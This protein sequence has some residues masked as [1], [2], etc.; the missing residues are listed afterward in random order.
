M[1]EYRGLTIRIGADT[2][3]FTQGIKAMQGAISDTQKNLNQLKKAL[4]FD[5]TSK[6]A[7][8]LYVGELQSQA[9]AATSKVALLRKGIDELNSSMSRS[10]SGKTIGEL[11]SSTDNVELSARRAR[12]SYN[13][14]TDALANVYT[15][16]SKLS[17]ETFD[18]NEDEI[19]KA[20]AELKA[21]GMSASEAKRQ[22][23]EMSTGK[24]FNVE[25]SSI[26]EIVSELQRLIDKREEASKDDPNTTIGISLEEADETLEAIIRM[27]GTWEEYSAALKDANDVST[28]RKYTVEVEKLE[29]QIKSISKAEADVIANN[30]NAEFEEGMQSI[31]DLDTELERAEQRFRTLDE[32]LR[33]DPTNFDVARQRAQALAEATD[34][35]KQKAQALKDKLASMSD[36]EF[37]KMVSEAKNLTQATSEIRDKFV[38]SYS[39]VQRLESMLDRVHS[40]MSKMEVDGQKNTESFSELEEGAKEIE[41]ELQKVKQT[42]AETRSELT[43]SIGATYF[44]QTSDEATEAQRK[45]AELKSEAKTAVGEISTSLYMALQQISQYSERALNSVVDATVNLDDALTEARKTVDGLDEE[46]FQKLKDSAVELSKTQPID[47]ATIL[48]AEALGGQLGV[49]AESVEEFAKVVTGLDVSTNM[50]W[51]TAASEMARFFNI[52]K[53]EG[54]DPADFYQNYG[55]AIVDL[56]NNFATTESEI[57]AMAMRIASAG[58][59]IGMSRADVLGLSAALTSMGVTAE[60]GGSSISTIM[61][62]IDKSVAMGTGG[63]EKYATELGT[64]VEG[65]LDAIAS[66]DDDALDSMGKRFNMTGNNFKKEILGYVDSLGAWSET[67]AK[68]TERSAEDFASAWKADPA[69]TLAA[70]FMGIDGAVD[71]GDNLALILDDLGITSIRQLDLSRRMASNSELVKRGIEDANAAWQENTALETEVARRNES[72]SGQMDIMKNSLDAIKTELGEGLLPIVKLGVGYFQDFSTILDGWSTEAKTAAIVTLGMVTALTTLATIVGTVGPAMYNAYAGVVKLAGVLS[73]IPSALAAH[74]ITSFGDA[75]AAAQ[76]GVGSLAT[77]LFSLSSVGTLLA[78]TLGVAALAAIVYFSKKAY[79]ARKRSDEFKAAISGLDSATR[80]LKSDFESSAEGVES[81]SESVGDAMSVEELTEELNNLKSAAEDILT[82]MNES[83]AMLDKYY[84]VISKY[85]GKGGEATGELEWAVKGLNDTLGTTFEAQDILNGY[86]ETEMGTIENLCGYIDNLIEKRK[87]QAKVD[88]SQQ[89]YTDAYAEYLKLEQNRVKAE[90]EYQELLEREQRYH[91]GV[92]EEELLSDKW[93]TDALKNAY[94]T[95]VAAE[96]AASAAADYTREV[97][98]LMDSAYESQGKLGEMQ[99]YIQSA[100]AGMDEDWAQ[101]LN[102]VQALGD[103]GIEDL[104]TFTSALV[105]AGVSVQDLQNIMDNPSV[106]FADMVREAG[107][108]AGEAG[109]VLGI[110]ID[111]INDYN[112]KEG[113]ATLELDTD[114]ATEGAE[115]AKEEIESQEIEVPM[116]VKQEGTAN[117]D[118][119]AASTGGIEIP[120]TLASG[121][122]MSQ[123]SETKGA[124]DELTSADQTI[125]VKADD[126]DASPKLVNV[127]GLVNNIPTGKTIYVYANTSSADAALNSLNSRINAMSSSVTV[128]T[129]SAAGGIRYHADGMIVDRPS[130]LGT[131]DIVGEA[132]AEAIIPLTNRRY[133]KPFADTV[134]EGMLSQL[135]DMRNETTYNITVNAVGD[136]GDDIARAITRELRAHELMRRG[137]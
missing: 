53:N 130:W 107:E 18:L 6:S 49:A 126:S 116:T 108:E 97:E 102:W 94:E 70:I 44:R 76:L 119:L 105:A 125:V 20:T 5:S 75:I 79:E 15:N 9:V 129:K 50:D 2:T 54:E 72:L 57:S 45:I 58:Q 106:A 103:V 48:N 96:R 36:S 30:M 83:N 77:K 14:V 135:G 12:E 4:T 134:A 24:T 26:S 69:D 55:A 37:A 39:S 109:D 104:D 29:A 87:A 34:L 66:A 82:P 13:D 131:R 43:T 28:I 85:A 95:Q 137:R 38:E 68:E 35:A 78:G 112:G 122:T 19:E 93:Q 100:F 98:S 3:R 86:Y 110:L 81:F 73:T 60:A 123:L 120:V 92:S 91:P 128:A 47:A 8:T 25:R 16:L 56:G 67:W 64:T 88:A 32:T 61:N 117:I 1:A 27:K 17:H 40:A 113:K 51:N 74:G 114:P 124:L 59:A 63:L 22:V 90:S 115:A 71:A 118:N 127:V 46:G 31:R 23:A 21:M 42:A 84:E 52:M 33:L 121:D 80:S 7:A 99:A 136:T 89:L 101:S 111:K 11:A 65:M 62:N 10:Q 132:G 41:T 133:V